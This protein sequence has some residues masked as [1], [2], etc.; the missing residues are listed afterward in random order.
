MVTS[1][2]IRW[3]SSAR[4]RSDSSWMRILFLFSRYTNTYWNR[5]TLALS[6]NRK[7]ILCASI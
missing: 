2:I 6:R 5:G 1:I 7:G 4:K 3:M